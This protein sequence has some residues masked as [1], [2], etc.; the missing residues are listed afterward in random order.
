MVEFATGVVLLVMALVG[1]GVFFLGL[2]YL[3]GRLDE[4]WRRRLVRAAR[5]AWREQ[6]ENNDADR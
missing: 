1:A 4:L 5:D 6:K 2:A 3:I